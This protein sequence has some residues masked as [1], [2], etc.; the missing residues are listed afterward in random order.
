MTKA[1][2]I[3]SYIPTQIDILEQELKEEDD[4]IA[5]K[6]SKINVLK[7]IIRKKNSIIEYKDEL[8]LANETTIEALCMQLQ[9]SSAIIEKFIENNNDY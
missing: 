4:I 9:E 5:K 6:S 2:S 8:L 1:N 7:A 3:D